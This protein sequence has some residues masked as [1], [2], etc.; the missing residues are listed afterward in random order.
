MHKIPIIYPQKKVFF[1]PGFA[2]K[3]SELQLQLIYK[4]VNLHV[5][6]LLI[7]GYE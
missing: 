6:N 7:G 3:K 5:D 1:K 4:L 2:N